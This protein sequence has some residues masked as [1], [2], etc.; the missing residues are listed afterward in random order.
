VKEFK[1]EQTTYFEFLN[2]AYNADR[3]RPSRSGARMP[4][5]SHA[6]SARD[7]GTDQLAFKVANIQD[8]SFYRYDNSLPP[9]TSTLPVRA[10]FSGTCS[11]V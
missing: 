11:R 3:P 5:L 10:T 7:S 6:Q 4:E 2:S 9:S 1:Y 8:D